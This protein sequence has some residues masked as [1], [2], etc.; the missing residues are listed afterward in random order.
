[1]G[2]MQSFAEKDLLGRADYL[3]TVSGGGYLGGA[4]QMLRA[5]SRL[6]DGLSAPTAPV[7]RKDAFAPGSPEEDH[8]RRHGKYIADGFVQWVTALG[9][10]VRN[11]LL[12]LAVV[13]AALVVASFVLGWLYAQAR[14]WS[15]DLFPTADCVDGTGGA[16][17]AQLRAAYPVGTWFAVAIPLGLA[18]AAWVVSGVLSGG[19]GR[20]TAGTGTAGPVWGPVRRALPALV[21]GDR[22]GG[23]FTWRIVLQKVAGGLLVLG[24]AVL[25]LGV[26]GPA[27]SRAATTLAL[28][29]DRT[30]PEIGS[31]IGLVTSAVTLWNLLSRRNSGGLKLAQS[32]LTRLRSGAGFA[33]RALICAAVVL[34]LVGV[35][36]VVV[37]AGVA[38][39]VDVLPAGRPAMRPQDVT[40]WTAAV[41]LLVVMAALFDQTRMSLHPFYKRRLATAFNLQR[42]S[43]GADEVPWG[44]PSS[45]ST[46]GAPDT[47]DP[48]CPRLQLI[49]CASANLSGQ[50][51]V[52]PGRRVTPFVFT[53]DHVGGPDLGY[54]AT[55]DLQALVASRTYR[56]DVTVLAAMAISGA[57]VAS[58]MGRMSGPFDLLLALSNACLG[59]W[60]TQP[61]PPRP[62]VHRPRAARPAAGPL[63]QPATPGTA[64]ALLRPRADGQLLAGRPVRLRLRRRP[65]RQP[66]PA[67][68]AA[69]T[70]PHHLLRRRLR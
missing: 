21:L 50:D 35:A 53:S 30:P 15:V 66:G 3:A 61:A 31:L 56:S 25:A 24:L 19:T 44:D 49:L 39:T 48:G 17:C 6:S 12:G 64:P 11:V 26:G 46:L 5:R 1:M 16:P 45:L 14:P 23:T 4:H 9:V 67:G 33:V 41:V 7:N 47:D 40:W 69:P 54:I 2:A 27:L 60:G 34:G 22:E 29:H 20:D 65:L 18:F 43:S 58:A 59:V 70:L 52:P 28:G 51:D 63:A 36:L 10:V 68:A 37:G 55:T 57:A 13:L 42:T 62:L 38:R 8:V 32:T